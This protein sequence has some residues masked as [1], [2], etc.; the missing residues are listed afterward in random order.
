[1]SAV[2]KPSGGAATDAAFA[3]S[4]Q[5]GAASREKTFEA[6]FVR[7]LRQV[8]LRIHETENVEQIMLEV[9]PEICK[10]QIQ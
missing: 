3:D 9:S 1:M 5:P 4:Q 2:I 8:V 7:Q 6:L 10:L